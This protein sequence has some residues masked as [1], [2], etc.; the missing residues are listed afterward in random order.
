MVWL[1]QGGYGRRGIGMNVLLRLG[2]P[3]PE[4]LQQLGQP[5]LRQRSQLL[6]P[7]QQLLQTLPP[8]EIRCRGLPVCMIV[9]EC[10][11]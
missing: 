9:W 8:A 10:K 5:S 4:V 11:G 7:Q 2:P 1:R 6:L 3:R